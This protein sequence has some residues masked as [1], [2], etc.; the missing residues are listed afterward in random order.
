MG[1]EG[2]EAAMGKGE[3]V[4][5]RGGVMVFR[6]HLGGSW[7]GLLPKHPRTRLPWGQ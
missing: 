2:E 3:E 7:W 1:G 6:W 4:E 5:G